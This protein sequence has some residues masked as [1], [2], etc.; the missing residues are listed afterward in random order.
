MN[1]IYLSVYLSLEFVSGT[2]VGFRIEIWCIFARI[3]PRYLVFCVVIV[4]D[5]VLRL[6]FTIICY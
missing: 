1:T 2:F 5:I 3:I 6:Y 4:N